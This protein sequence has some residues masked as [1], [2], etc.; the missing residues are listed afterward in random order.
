MS[1]S[2]RHCRPASRELSILH[3]V[4]HQVGFVNVCVVPHLE[5]LEP[6]V[7][8]GPH[9]VPALIAMTAQ[10]ASHHAPVHNPNCAVL[11]LMQSNQLA[12]DRQHEGTPALG[13]H[14][15]QV[16]DQHVHL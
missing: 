11:F 12:H 3:P 9:T 15:T 5:L 6:P 7:V 14:T 4:L 1:Q 8:A 13:L 10:P 16:F 2:S